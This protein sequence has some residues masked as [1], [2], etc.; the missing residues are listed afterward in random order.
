M[1]EHMGVL[2]TSDPREYGYR[3]AQACPTYA[4]FLNRI[5]DLSEYQQEL[6]VEG[7]N[8]YRQDQRDYWED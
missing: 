8:E 4:Y 7:W 6:A 3:M 1:A 2:R 5:E